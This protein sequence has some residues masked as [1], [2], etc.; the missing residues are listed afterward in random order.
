MSSNDLSQVRDYI[1]TRMSVVEPTYQEWKGSLEDIGNIP[2]TLLDRSYHITLNPTTSTEQSDNFIQETQNVFISVFKQGFTS[3]IEAR[4]ELMQIANC[5][6]LDIINFKNVEDYKAANDGNI[7]KV[8]SI[9]IT[10][11]DIDATNDNIIKA[12]IEIDVVLF[13]ATT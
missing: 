11:N 5:I 1:N 13:I 6:R 3:S 10:P 4:D 7:E 9:G 12:T 8:V 2:K